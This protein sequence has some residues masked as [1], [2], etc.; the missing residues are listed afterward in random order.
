MEVSMQ[1][2]AASFAASILLGVL[3]GVLYDAVRFSRV[4]LFI[5][6]LISCGARLAP[7]DIAELPAAGAIFSGSFLPRSAIFCFSPSPQC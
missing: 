6:V 7:F 5:D 1:A 4:L 3:F 2:Q